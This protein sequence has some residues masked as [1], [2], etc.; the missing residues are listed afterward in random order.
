MKMNRF[1]L[2]FLLL[3][4]QVTSFAQTTGGALT[5]T[6]RSAEGA[7]E[8]ASVFL[9]KDRETQEIVQFAVSD[10]AGHFTMSAPAGN[11][12]FGVSYL[13]YAMHTE[14]ISLTAEPL[15]LGTITLETSAEELQ[16]VVVR[17]QIVGVRTQPDGFAV[18]VREI[19]E[20]SNDALDLLKHI[21]KVQVKSNQLGIMG[22]EQVLVKIGNV[23]QRVD[24]SEIAGRLGDC[25]SPQGLRCG[26]DRPCGG[27]HAATA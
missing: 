2:V 1:L 26:S 11:Y 25:W 6:I 24:A 18:D 12:I 8:G 17:G 3:L 7:L 5:G 27:H 10:A 15:D 23:L 4:C 9:V 22:K 19:R 13:G 16:T 14:E 20:R 21:P